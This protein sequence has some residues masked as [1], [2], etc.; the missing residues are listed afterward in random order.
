ML[1]FAAHCGFEI[2]W[3]SISNGQE[4]N[5]EANEEATDEELSIYGV[6]YQADSGARAL[7]ECRGWSVKVDRSLSPDDKV[8]IVQPVEQLFYDIR[9]F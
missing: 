2:A 9:V 7:T 1:L 6:F 3:S 8:G 4:P 5:D